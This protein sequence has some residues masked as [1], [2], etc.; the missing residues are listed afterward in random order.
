MSAFPVE[1]SYMFSNMGRI[2]S[3]STDRSQK[4]I[5]NSAHLDSVLYN[6]FSTLPERGHVAFGS[7]TYGLLVDGV[8]GGGNGLDGTV[9]DNESNLLWMKVGQ[10]RPIE[11]LMLMPR[12]FLTVPFLGRG[13]CDPTIES[14]MQQGEI[15]RGRKSVTTVMEKAFVD[16]KTFPLEKGLYD[17]VQ[18]SSQ[19][20]QEVAMQGWA[21]GG[22]STRESGEEYFSKK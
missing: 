13:S 8:R 16:P 10:E 17:R 6:H 4:N 2:G 1:T 9:V 14:Q 21:R 7:A 18:D 11:K 3:D 20:I 15:V 12:P 22:S 5:Q 19:Q